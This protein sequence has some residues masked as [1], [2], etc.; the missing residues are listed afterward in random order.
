VAE[1]LDDLAGSW[2]RHLRA[3]GLAERSL[4]A[5]GQPVRYFTAWLAQQG[6]PQTLESLTRRAIETW[7]AGLGQSHAPG[8][9]RTY[10]KGLHRFCRWLTDEGELAT[11]PMAGM[12]VP[13]VP[14][15]P[16]PVITDDEL[17]RLLKA[18]AG[19]EFVDRR[20]EA[21]IRLLLDTGIRISELTGLKLGDLDLDAEVVHVMGKGRRPRSCPFGSKT[22]RA[23]DRY[24]RMRRTHPRASSDRLWL[25]QRGP[26]SID[27]VDERLRRRAEQ[28][29]IEGM[30][31]HRFRHTFAHAWLAAGGQERD[32][33]R[34][35]GWRSSEMV[36][37]YAASTADVRAREAH[38]RLALGD[39]L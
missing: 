25:S 23:L 30:H 37:R 14:D 34:L 32:L 29:G 21:M 31:A 12:P 6:R 22:A 16:V 3:A 2:R 17:V 11:S 28:A 5:Y 26:M 39:R 4:A 27:G 33:M 38:R 24:V 9:L 13:S 35:A 7:L 18:C 20:D 15:R 19:R 8:T 1:R 10:Y 36:G